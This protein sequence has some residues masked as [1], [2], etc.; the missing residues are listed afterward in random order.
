MTYTEIQNADQRLYILKSL[1]NT[2]YDANEMMLIT[3]LEA[4]G[5]RVSHSGMLKHLDFLAAN[6]LVTLSHIANVTKAELTIKGQDVSDG[7]EVVDG[8][9][10]PKA[11][12]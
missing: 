7:R 4:F 8:V 9:R 10:K 3:A 11:G 1:V 6:G 2:G 5:H 12:E